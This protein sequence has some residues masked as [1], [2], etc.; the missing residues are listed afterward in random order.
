MYIW[1]LGV[2]LAQQPTSLG[3]ASGTL[4]QTRIGLEKDL[5]Q[6]RDLTLQGVSAVETLAFPLPRNWELAADPELHLYFGHSSTLLEDRSTLTVRV[7]D[8]GVGSLALSPINATD[9]ELIVRIPRHMLKDFNTLSFVVDQHYTRDC[10][11]P[12]DPSLWTRVARTSALD[13]TY[14]TSPVIPDLRDFPYPFFDRRGYGPMRLTLV[15]PGPIDPGTAAAAGDLAFALSRIADYR[16]L[17]FSA[18]VPVVE[19]AETGALLI[20]TPQE[21]PEILRFLKA[22][23]IA[24]P[25]VA[26]AANPADPSLPVLII[27]GPDA[28]AVGTATRA[29]ASSS[30]Y[31]ALA[32]SIARISNEAQ[33][34]PPA[35]EAGVRPVPAKESYR[36][37]ELGMK[38]T[39]VRGFYAPPITIP[40]ILPADSRPRTMG[41][42]LTIHYSYAAQLQTGL[43]SLEVMVNNVSLRSV[44]LD[45]AAGEERASIKLDIP[46]DILSPYSEIKVLFHLYHKDFGSCVRVADR[47]LWGTVWADSTLELPLD[48]YSYLP[49]LSLLQYRYWP[50]FQEQGETWIT[51]VDAPTADDLAAGMQVAAEMGRR[52][53]TESWM[54][55]LGMSSSVPTNAT[56]RI[57]LLS[58]KVPHGLYDRLAQAGRITSSGELSRRLAVDGSILLDTDLEASYR[59]LEEVMEEPEVANLVLRAPDPRSLLALSVQVGRPETLQQLAGNLAVIGPDGQ[60]RTLSVVE[61][62]LVGNIPAASTGRIYLQEDWI[63]LGLGVPLA[64]LLAALVGRAV[65]RRGGTTG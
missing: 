1:T 65:R 38:D 48:R 14:R 42:Q 43:S 3:D 15:H 60:V 12:F 59:T 55:H 29:L 32:G 7:N 17:E 24:G 51:M 31:Q 44:P 36:L 40:L 33:G 19:N 16:G 28:A 34:Q 9:G 35:P 46:P 54:V 25:V 52:S 63:I 23:D 27:T 45:Q 21:V 20:G 13:F 11:D 58:W 61:R 53:T 5:F 30:R 2:V 22:E 56:R 26:E 57:L 41:G 49:D 64:L 4:Q 47:H 8:Q 50:V 39:T 62:R 37:A 18:P 10:E 6:N